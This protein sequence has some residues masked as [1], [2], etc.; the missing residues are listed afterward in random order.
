M[1]INPNGKSNLAETYDYRVISEGE[2]IDNQA[3]NRNACLAVVENLKEEELEVLGRALITS[4]I[5]IFLNLGDEA[6]RQKR[7]DYALAVRRGD[8]EVISHE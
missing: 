7:A 1:L 3:Y 6:Y 4:D 8:D 2:Y 5:D